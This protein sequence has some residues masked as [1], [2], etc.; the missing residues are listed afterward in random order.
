MDNYNLLTDKL[1]SLNGGLITTNLICEPT[2]EQMNRLIEG[3][4]NP[5]AE[6]RQVNSSAGLAVNY[7]RAYEM[8]HKDASVEFEWKKRKPLQYG[9]PA[10]IDVV[11]REKNH[12]W[13]VESKFLEPY[14]SGNEMP[15]DSY[16]DVSKYSS[17]TKDSPESWVTLFQNAKSF[18]YYNVTQLCRHLLAI[19]KDI[20]KDSKQ[21]RGKE[22]MLISAVWDMP[23]S[24]LMLFAD[25]EREIL[26]LRR[27]II[28]EEAMQS[29]VFFNE[30][31]NM[32]LPDMSIKYRAIKYNDIIDQII[33]QQLL[34][35]LK[36]QYYL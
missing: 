12:V 9:I 13:F 31:I 1:K 23:N 36:Q 19:T 33:D 8:C 30:F 34:A 35:K 6:M 32:H 11:I 24:F 20:Q 25:E 17:Y 22:V 28:R 4:G 2:E 21:Y 18:Q 29:E 15:V 27:Q 26:S 14:Y 16:E 7:W 3:S 5:E 10:N